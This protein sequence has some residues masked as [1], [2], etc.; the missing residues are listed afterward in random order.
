MIICLA[1][2]ILFFT[3]ENKIA[4]WRNVTNVSVDIPFPPNLKIKY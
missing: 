1:A 3:L 2:L 4:H